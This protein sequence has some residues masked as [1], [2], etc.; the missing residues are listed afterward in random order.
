MTEEAIQTDSAVENAAVEHSFTVQTLPGEWFQ[1]DV[2]SGPKYGCSRQGGCHEI[3][4][5]NDP[6]LG[7]C[8][9]MTTNDNDHSLPGTNSPPLGGCYAVHRVGGVSSCLIAPHS[10]PLNVASW[11]R[12]K[13]A[14]PSHQPNLSGGF[15]KSMAG[16]WLSLHESYGPPFQGAPVTALAVYDDPVTGKLSFAYGPAHQQVSFWAPL[17]FDEWFDFI[18]EVV[19]STDPKVGG[20]GVDLN[21]QRLRSRAGNMWQPYATI[22]A[23][24][25]AAG[26]ML[27]YE[28][29]YRS[30]PW[31]GTLRVCFQDF[32][33]GNSLASVS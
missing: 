13:V 15:P 27:V 20:A 2:N 30:I 9:E 16:K 17:T 3:N 33:I 4:T 11:I 25:K 7:Q 32:R 12:V 31:G 19:P 24:D 10:L 1:I 18:I 14:I 21:G 26:S 8:I 29:N 5:I 6:V 23:S 22:I 28:Q